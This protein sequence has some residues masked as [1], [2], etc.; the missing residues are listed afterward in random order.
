MRNEQILIG[1]TTAILCLIGL[2]YDHWFLE[3]TEK[4]R[5]LARWFGPRTALWILRIGFLAGAA[6]GVLLALDILHPIEWD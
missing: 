1:S 3:Q 5:R 4:G 2:R 6:F